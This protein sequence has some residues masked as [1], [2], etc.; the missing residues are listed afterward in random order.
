MNKKNGE[1]I[2]RFSYRNKA[3]SI[4]STAETCREQLGKA[5]GRAQARAGEHAAVETGQR[6]RPSPE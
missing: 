2:S 6:A 4:A 3:Q 1:I 5:R